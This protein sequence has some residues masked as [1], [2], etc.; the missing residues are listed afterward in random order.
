[1]GWV[2][3]LLDRG[4]YCGVIMGCV[5]LL[6]GYYG[7]GSD[8]VPDPLTQPSPP[9]SGVAKKPQDVEMTEVEAGS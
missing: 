1:M 8:G 3:L 4:G 9:F 7:M 2:G 5:G 6:W